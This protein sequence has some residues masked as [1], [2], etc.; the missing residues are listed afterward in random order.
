VLMGHRERL[1]THVIPYFGEIDI[2]YAVD[3]GIHR[4]GG[5]FFLDG[6][7]GA[8]TAALTAPYADR[9]GAGTL[10]HQDDELAER[11]HNAH[12]AGMQIGVHAIGD[13]AIEQAISVWERVYRSLDSRLRRH[14][15]A[16]RHRLEH[17]EMPSM[18]QLERAAELGLAISAQPAFDAEWGAGGELY[19]RRLGADRSIP[20]NP[21]RAMLDRGLVLGAGS[22]APVTALDPMYSIWALEHHHEETQRLSRAEAVRVCTIG[23]ARLAH[24]ED[25]KG[26]LQPGAHADFAV[27]ESDPFEA[28]E[29]LGLRPVLTVSQGRE[30]FAR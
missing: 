14:F 3:F 13:A 24:L 16:R 5:D 22:D 15:R 4:L 8:G 1:P 30:V 17:F 18:D 27:Y 12:L 7:I 10:Y 20:M 6:S 11:F 19:E 21:F 2:P 29:I 23:A 9:E 28:E 26:R 25:K